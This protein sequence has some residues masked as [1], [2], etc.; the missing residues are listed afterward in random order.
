MPPAARTLV[1]DPNPGGL[2]QELRDVPVTPG[3]TLRTAWLVV[4]TGGRAHNLAVDQKVDARLAGHLPVAVVLTFKVRD[5]NIIR[6]NRKRRQKQ[7]QESR[8]MNL[9]NRLLSCDFPMSS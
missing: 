3:Q 9:H 4:R 8:Y 2:A 5:Q 7:H 1:D 6:G